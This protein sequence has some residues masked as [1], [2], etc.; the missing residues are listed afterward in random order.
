MIPRVQADQGL[1]RAALLRSLL[2]QAPNGVLIH[3]RLAHL[4]A[5]SRDTVASRH[6]LTIAGHAG[7][8]LHWY[9]ADMPLKHCG[10]NDRQIHRGH[11]GFAT[12][13]DNLPSV[14]DNRCWLACV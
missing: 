2:A 7:T 5:A 3:L 14:Y 13:P 8:C 1:W 4:V 10:T 6:C 11:A 12:D 9:R